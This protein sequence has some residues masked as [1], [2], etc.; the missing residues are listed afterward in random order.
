[1]YTTLPIYERLQYSAQNIKFPSKRSD[2]QP[3]NQVQATA[4][5]L[6]VLERMP[7]DVL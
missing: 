1:M 2:K 5:V 6:I 7:K 4:D 3:V